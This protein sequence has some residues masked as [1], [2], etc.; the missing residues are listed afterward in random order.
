MKVVGS[1]LQITH[2]DKTD[3]I[4]QALQLVDAGL[5]SRI[6]VWCSGASSHTAI[7]VAKINAYGDEQFVICCAGNNHTTI[8]MKPHVRYIDSDNRI[9]YIE[10][11]CEFNNNHNRIPLRIA[12][13][14]DY[15]SD[16]PEVNHA[17]RVDAIL[18][19]INIKNAPDPRTV[20]DSMSN[21]VGWEGI[22]NP[23]LKT[24]EA[25]HSGKLESVSVCGKTYRIAHVSTFRRVEQQG[26]VGFGNEGQY[27][28]VIAQLNG[29]M[30]FCIEEDKT[31]QFLQN[32]NTGMVG[33]IYFLYSYV[34]HSTVV[35]YEPSDISVDWIGKVIAVKDSSAKMMI[36]GITDTEI[37]LGLDN[38]PMDIAFNLFTW[39]DGT[40]FGKT[41]K[42]TI[43]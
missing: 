11:L 30:C 41:T 5:I 42:L 4:K 24:V 12:P 21:P 10:S 37:I 22:E 17:D 9:K 18:G 2:Y 3:T 19:V 20:G 13:L 32:H 7:R 27:L 39:A 33:R 26:N 38:Y 29:G 6:D 23:L 34:D 1:V 8:N 14:I 36:L 16:V 25:I 40:P 31:L 43:N 35:A 28:I 15:V